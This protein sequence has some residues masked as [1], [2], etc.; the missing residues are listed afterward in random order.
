MNKNT[1]KKLSLA[2][3][4][5]ALGVICSAFYIPIGASK[6]FPVQHMI[7]VL[8][9]IILGPV[10]GVSMAFVTSFIRV[11]M[12]TGTLLAFPGSMI[13]AFISGLLFLYTKKY[14]FAYMGEVIG[15]GILGA[16]VAYPI[17]TLI[18]GKEAAIFAFVIPFIT[19]S[20]GGATIS[21]LFIEVLK[22]SN[23]L[24][25]VQNQVNT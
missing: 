16:I 17:A 19:S 11:M 25:Q 20:F 12:G 8:A 9:G 4:L 2:G 6:C 7:N 24:E 21:I 3:M 5:I 10:Y 14:I 23:I 22:K 13:G 1:V 15:T 18:M